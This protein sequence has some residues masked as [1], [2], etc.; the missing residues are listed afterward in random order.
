MECSFQDA[1]QEIGMS[2]YQVWGRLAGHH[3]MALVMPSINLH[4]AKGANR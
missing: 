4:T 1:K 3:H 2:R